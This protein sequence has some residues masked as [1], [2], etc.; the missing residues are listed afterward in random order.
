MHKGG[1]ALAEVEER[2][3][4]FGKGFFWWQLG[5]YSV[6]DFDSAVFR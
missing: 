4:G 3:F 1:F 6:P 2:G 5:V